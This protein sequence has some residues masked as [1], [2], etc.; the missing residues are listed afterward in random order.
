MSDGLQDLPEMSLCP[1]GP[2]EPISNDR[3]SLNFARI[4]KKTGAG[5]KSVC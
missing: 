3:R 5:C 4:I 2:P 1:G